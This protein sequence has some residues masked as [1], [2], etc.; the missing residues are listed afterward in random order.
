MEYTYKVRICLAIAAVDIHNSDN[1]RFLLSK[2]GQRLPT[3]PLDYGKSVNE[4]A[5]DFFYDITGFAST[6]YRLLQVGAINTENKDE[7]LI[8]YAMT[9][10]NI[11][12]IKNGEYEWGDFSQ[13]M[14]CNQSLQIIGY[15]CHV[16]KVIQ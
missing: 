16:Y 2:E 13:L 1:S 5:S 11:C 9:I 10:P 4:A 7:L 3:K 14:S 12:N 6:W 8:I 15:A